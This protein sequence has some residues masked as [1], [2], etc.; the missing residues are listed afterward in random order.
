LILSGTEDLRTPYDQARLIA[1]DYPGARLLAVPHTGHS[2]LS[3][4]VG[5][6]ATRAVVAFLRGGQPASACPSG[7]RPSLLA[8]AKPPPP[9]LAA[10]RGRSRAQR[11]RVAARLTARDAIAQVLTQGRRFGG[12]RGGSGRLERKRLVLDDYEYVPGVEIDGHLRPSKGNKPA[13]SVF[14]SVGATAPVFVE[15]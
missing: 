7:S 3:S 5:R 1:A 11:L 8:V 4:A 14:V 15:L 9:R 13:G 12:L 2:V 10:V 6:C